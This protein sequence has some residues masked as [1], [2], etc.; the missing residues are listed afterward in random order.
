MTEPIDRLAA[1]WS[2]AEERIAMLVLTRPD[3]YERY[4]RAARL[5]ADA[6]ADVGAPDALA[7]AYEEGTA[8]A[9][10]VLDEAGLLSQGLS[11]PQIAGAGFAIRHRELARETARAAAAERI[12]EARRR[13]DAWVVVEERGRPDAPVPG[14]YRR[15]E[16]RLEDA[17][18]LH[19]FVEED[20][21][22]GRPRYGVERV[23]LDPETGD[24]TGRPA[25]RETFAERSEW[26]R[27]VEELR[28][29]S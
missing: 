29:S 2:A 1:E 24:A 20:P 14:V 26:E 19:A 9:E 6:L 12:R 4:L 17:W 18:G 16:M 5:V 11:A 10:R 21:A 7:A 22:T 3:A 15:L 13:G 28:G 25:G 27:R 23:P 8:L